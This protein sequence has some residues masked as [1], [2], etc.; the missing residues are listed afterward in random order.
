MLSV[1]KNGD[2]VSFVSDHG[3]SELTP[4]CE[5]EAFMHEFFRARHT[6]Q[7]H[8]GLLP[9]PMSRLKLVVLARHRKWRPQDRCLSVICLAT[10]RG[11]GLVGA[12]DHL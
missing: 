10:T 3:T 12:G 1:G 5:E 8:I 6:Q 11:C 7:I 4:M 2:M 9:N